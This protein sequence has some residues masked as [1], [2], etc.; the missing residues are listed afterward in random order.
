MFTQLKIAIGHK[1]LFVCMSEDGKTKTQGILL[2]NPLPINNEEYFLMVTFEV[3]P[4]FDQERKASLNFLGGFDN[5]TI[6]EDISKETT[7]LAFTYPVMEIEEL[8]KEIGS[9]D[10]RKDK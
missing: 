9:I 10:F 5:P 7:F 3:I 1:K 8:A 2:S 6:V 4:M